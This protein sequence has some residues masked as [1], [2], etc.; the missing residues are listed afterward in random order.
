MITPGTLK[1]KK[2]S[3]LVCQQDSDEYLKRCEEMERKTLI[4]TVPI[5]STCLRMRISSQ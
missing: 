4:V 5:Q 2:S 1:K 3:R